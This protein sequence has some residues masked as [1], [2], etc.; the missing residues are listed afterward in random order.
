MANNRTNNLYNINLGDKAQ[1]NIMCATQMYNNIKDT[2]F[3]TC[4]T[5]RPIYA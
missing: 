5:W 1:Q 3:Y 4:S 2:Y